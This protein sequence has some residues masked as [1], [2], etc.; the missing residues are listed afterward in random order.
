MADDIREELRKQIQDSEGRSRLAEEIVDKLDKKLQP[1]SDV[2]K[3][4]ANK[5]VDTAKEVGGFVAG[6]QQSKEPPGPDPG[7]ISERE[8]AEIAQEEGMSFKDA[9]A[10]QIHEGNPKDERIPFKG[11]V[12]R[13]E[14][15][16][17][18]DA[19]LIARLGVEFAAGSMAA[20]AAMLGKLGRL[21]VSL[22]GGLGQA[23]GSLASETFDPS[24]DPIDRALV[25]GFVGGVGEGVGQFLNKIRKGGTAL[26]EGAREAID[27]IGDRA[28]FLPGQASTSMLVDIP[29][30]LMENAASAAGPLREAQKLMITAATDDVVKFVESFR[31][32]ASFEDVGKLLQD[33]V[34]DNS[35]AWRAV[36][37]HNFALLDDA[38]ISA[39]SATREFVD[40]T[41]SVKRAHAILSASEGTRKLIPGRI[42]VAKTVLDTAAKGANNAVSWEEAQRL[43]SALL[44]VG[45]DSKGLI[46][47][48][49]VATA[50]ELS[51]LV[52]RAMENA[53]RDISPDVLDLWR[54]ANKFWKK[55]RKV[56]DSTLARSI[57]EKDPEVIFRLTVNKNK[58]GTIRKLKS[59]VLDP[60][61]VMLTRLEKAKAQQTWREVQGEFLFDMIQKG[62]EEI[63]GGKSIRKLARIGDPAIA[64]LFNPNEVGTLRQ[65]LRTLELAQSPTG[66][67]I[68]GGWIMQF[69]QAGALGLF[70]KG[71]PAAATGIIVIPRLGAHLFR[72]KQFAHWATIGI[73]AK[74]GTDRAVE[75]FTRMSA[76]A[77]RE[78]HLMDKND[79]R[80]REA[81]K[82]RPRD[83]E[84]D[85][86]LQIAR[87]IGQLTQGTQ[88]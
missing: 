69:Q 14:L 55:G 31:T 88:P 61:G 16:R 20:R 73:N 7:L 30:N 86:G 84:A 11:A 56:F 75:A 26:E 35:D 28:V 33:T 59:M 2:I 12:T 45:R 77:I 5:I 18:I 42:K 22:A 44:A 72:N 67:N 78:K 49:P 10:R 24:R 58:P 34:V 47:G 79:K 54:E 48:A 83:L 71:E 37:T 82:N 81:E 17:E 62:E 64:E 87:S 60:P 40:L 6:S 25:T 43:R 19:G 65:V 21:G 15:P 39:G 36:A 51:P 70:L 52:D 46:K 13:E 38:L 63:L 4:V 9:L 57:V 41:D 1:A 8:I 74:P 3:P 53:A 29:Q 76:I 68:P 50:K 85:P 66:K 27:Q 32:V 23:A 80:I